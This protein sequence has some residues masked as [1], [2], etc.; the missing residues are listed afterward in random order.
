MVSTLTNLTDQFSIQCL[1]NFQLL[2]ASYLILENIEVSVSS[3]VMLR[4]IRAGTDSGWTRNESQE[5]VTKSI[6][7]K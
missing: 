3:V 7:G 1:I 6:L 2:V 4:V 5:M